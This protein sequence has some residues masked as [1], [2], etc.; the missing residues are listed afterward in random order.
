LQ[1]W[2]TAQPVAQGIAVLESGIELSTTSLY[3]FFPSQQ[4]A[5]DVHGGF[6]LCA[7]TLANP[8]AIVLEAMDSAG[9]AYP[10]YV[11]FVP[12]SANLGTIAMGGCT[13]TCGPAPDQLQTTAPA[14]ITG[15][16]ASTPIAVSG[17]VVPQYVMDALDGSKSA[18]GSPNLWALAMPVFN[19]STVLTFSTTAGACAG[20]APYCSTYTITVPS[21]GPVWPESG[22]TMQASVS[23]TYLIYAV[24]GSGAACSPP[25][26]FTP[27]QQDGKSFL[28]ATPGAQLTAANLSFSSCH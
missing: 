28:T 5:A 12:G 6:S 18:A 26:G 17:T 1:D 20:V 19:A 7:Q 10:P 8:S 21:Q 3:N 9:K 11:A 13:L 2:V 14:T 15:V 22:G 23:P 25:F 4:T 27:F 24:S 16:I